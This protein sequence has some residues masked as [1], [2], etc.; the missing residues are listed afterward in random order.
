MERVLS[1]KERGLM[2]T[3]ETNDR[4]PRTP[5]ARRLQTSEGG[6]VMNFVDVHGHAACAEIAE[7]GGVPHQSIDIICKKHRHRRSRD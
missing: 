3:R 4:S 7:F 6:D 1:D 5:S 2:V